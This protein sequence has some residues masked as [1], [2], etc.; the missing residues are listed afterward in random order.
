MNN[1]H[2]GDK[3]MTI[4]HGSTWTI[5]KSRGETQREGSQNIYERVQE[6]GSGRT[7]GGSS[8]S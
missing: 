6:N 2:L 8:S 5:N 4:H 1:P 3:L 7:E